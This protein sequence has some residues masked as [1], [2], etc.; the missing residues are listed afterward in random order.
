MCY[1]VERSDQSRS[2]DRPEN[3]ENKFHQF[4]KLLDLEG[5]LR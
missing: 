3:D 5:E 4:L 2:H 1:E